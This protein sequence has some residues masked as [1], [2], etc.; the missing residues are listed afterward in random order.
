MCSYKKSN[1]LH[2]RYWWIGE[3]F[4]VF[5][6]ESPWDRKKNRFTIDYRT[7]GSAC[8]IMYFVSETG[9]L[10]ILRARALTAIMYM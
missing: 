3:S 8:L 4:R 2:G 1:C 6:G 10:T 9:V 5:R 7:I